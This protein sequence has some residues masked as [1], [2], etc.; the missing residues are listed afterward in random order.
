MRYFIFIPLAALSV[1][2]FAETVHAPA[3]PTRPPSLSQPLLSCST[4]Q[5]RSA[6]ALCRAFQAALSGDACNEQSGEHGT[7]YCA[8]AKLAFERKDCSES[9]RGESQ[10]E[11][12]RGIAAA[13]DRKNCVLFDWR[14]RRA[15]ICRGAM[16]ALE[17]RNCFDDKVAS[18]ALVRATCLALS[19]QRFRDLGLSH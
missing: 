13:L 3:T 11:A 2:A 1:T 17:A 8:G 4:I 19:A 14:A 10:G 5:E 16:L 9:A 12:C 18:N 6:Q 7:D 15:K